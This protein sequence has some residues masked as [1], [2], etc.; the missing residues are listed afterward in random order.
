MC[1][2]LNIKEGI[3]I[4]GWALLIEPMHM[5]LNIVDYMV[6]E[7]SKLAVVATKRLTIWLTKA[8]KLK[9]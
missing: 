3:D 8:V 4:S 2:Y 1:L 9:S 7:N 6:N 5:V